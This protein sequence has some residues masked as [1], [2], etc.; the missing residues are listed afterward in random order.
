MRDWT[1]W[2]LIVLLVVSAC[3]LLKV[4]AVGYVAEAHLAHALPLAVVTGLSAIALAIHSK[5]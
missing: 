2:L 3:S 5:S 1:K 4:H